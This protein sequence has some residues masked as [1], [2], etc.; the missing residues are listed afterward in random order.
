MTLL[1]QQ[2]RTLPFLASLALAAVI[3]C[4]KDVPSSADRIGVAACDA[5]LDKM[6]ECQRSGAGGPA[7]DLMKS[8][9]SPG[10][11]SSI[12]G[13]RAAYKAQAATNE[14]R[15]TLEMTCPKMLDALRNSPG[16]AKVFK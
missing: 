6:V 15:A 14:G 10:I 11:G 16:C 8:M 3:G 12:D 5:F 4:K 9:G 2:I 1:S 7:L 13:M